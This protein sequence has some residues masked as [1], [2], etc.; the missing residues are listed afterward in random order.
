MNEQIQNALSRLKETIS[1]IERLDNS[2]WNVS[3]GT[4]HLRAYAEQIVNDAK[5]LA[6]HLK[7]YGN[8]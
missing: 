3:L 4:S 8:K 2:Y 6:A 1:E 5:T 7:S